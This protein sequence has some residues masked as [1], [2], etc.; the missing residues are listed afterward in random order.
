MRTK[1]PNTHIHAHT[2]TRPHIS[3][4]NLYPLQQKDTNNAMQSEIP[5]DPPDMCAVTH[6]PNIDTH[7]HMHRHTLMQRGFLNR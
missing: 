1:H 3:I 7:T 2:Q 5:Q 4:V 6:Q